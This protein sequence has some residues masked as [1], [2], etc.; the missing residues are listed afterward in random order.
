MAEEKERNDDRCERVKHREKCNAYVF[1][2]VDTKLICLY[3]ALNK[4]I[5]CFYTNV[6]RSIEEA[7]KYHGN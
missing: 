7:I 3:I 1:V 6:S 4:C 5:K 2:T